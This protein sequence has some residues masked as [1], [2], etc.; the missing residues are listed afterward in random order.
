[1]VLE[2]AHMEIK[3][4]VEQEF[5]AAVRQAKPLFLNFPGC[6][7]IEL[8]RSIER[9]QVYRLFIQWET[10]EHHTIDFRQSEKYPEWRSMVGSFFAAPPVVEH[11]Q[12]VALD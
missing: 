4:G 8:N 2:I 10:L 12:V 11:Q 6:L 5:E 9:P 3:P 1:M 7:G